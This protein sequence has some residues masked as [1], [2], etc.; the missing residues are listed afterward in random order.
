MDDDVDLV[1]N[2]LIQ[3]ASEAGIGHCEGKIQ[4][5]GE[6]IRMTQINCKPWHFKEGDIVALAILYDPLRRPYTNLRQHL[7]FRGD[8]YPDEPNIA[9]RRPE[10]LFQN[11]QFC[12]E[13]PGHC[14][15]QVGMGYKM[16]MVIVNH[17]WMPEYYFHVE[18][19]GWL[20]LVVFISLALL[21]VYKLFKFLKNTVSAYLST[22][23]Y[24]FVP[25]S[26]TNEAV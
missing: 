12:G 20:I 17:G 18:A 5:Q 15:S 23:D 4:W 7:I 22:S 2:E 21:G 1:A 19:V 10:L 24:E 26:E 6:E 11:T 8:W 14:V 25:I 16:Y 3:S 9:D 13:N